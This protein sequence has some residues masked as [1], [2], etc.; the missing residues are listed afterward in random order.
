VGTVTCIF[1]SS[2]IV[3]ER[4]QQV[5]AWVAGSKR[6]SVTLREDVKPVRY[7]C[8]PCIRLRQG[9][10]LVGQTTLGAGA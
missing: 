3:G 9:G 4:Y 2:I 10:V 7:A 8:R 6:D 1:C 5:T